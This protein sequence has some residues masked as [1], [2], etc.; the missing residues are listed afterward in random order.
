MPL[1]RSDWSGEGTVKAHSGRLL[2]WSR[3]RWVRCAA[4]AADVCIMAADAELFLTAPFNAEDKVKAA[5]SAEFAAKA[6]VAAIVEEDAVK[7]ASAAARVVGMLPANNWLAPPCLISKL[8]PLCSTWSSMMPRALPSYCRC[9]HLTEL[10]AGYG[11]N[12]YTALGSV[13]GQAV[14][15]VATA[16]GTLCTSAPLRQPVL[17]ACA[18]LTAFPL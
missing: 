5:G 3:K 2:V 6:G 4:A 15:I 18:M 11:R 8:P 10:Y 7:A 14:G 13:N 1:G 12:I 17:C 16:K 9:R